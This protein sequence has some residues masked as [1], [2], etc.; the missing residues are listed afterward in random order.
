LRDLFE[1]GYETIKEFNDEALHSAFRGHHRPA[2][3]MSQNR[4]VNPKA[5]FGEFVYKVAVIHAVL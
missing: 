4:K 5:F 2:V 3:S 1:V